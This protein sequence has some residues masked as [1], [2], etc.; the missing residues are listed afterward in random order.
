MPIFV[1]SGPSGVGKTTLVDAFLK[2]NNFNI[3]R[4]VTYTTRSPRPSEID[5]VQYHFIDK[6]AFEQK[7]QK[8]E[9]LEYSSSYDAF[10]GTSI[11]IVE[12]ERAGHSFILVADLSGSIAIKRA[13]SKAIL[14]WLL[15]PS[16][17]KLH[18]RL[19][20]RTGSTTEL[21]QKRMLIAYN[22]LFSINQ[23]I[24]FDYRIIADQIDCSLQKLV[25]IIK[26]S[27][28]FSAQNDKKL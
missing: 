11:D 1:I 20:N 21:V 19:S 4:V 6:K 9:F 27:F 17:H 22:E 12:Q 26:Q 2:N 7:I 18:D 15:P 8:G 24:E 3:E 5:G 16:M 23:L 13:I 25:Q 14:I 10:Y 28:V